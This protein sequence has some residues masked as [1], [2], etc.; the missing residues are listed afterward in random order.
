MPDIKLTTSDGLIETTI[1]QK[2][3]IYYLVTNDNLNSIKG[4]SILYDIFV[5]IAS[6]FWGAY[7]SILITLKSIS[8]D[9][10]WSSTVLPLLTLQDVFLCMSI[11]FTVLTLCMLYVSYSGLA[12]IKK[13]DV[14]NLS[15]TPDIQRNLEQAPE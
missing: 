3:E 6:I 9:D 1:K 8:V 2:Q 5:F 15:W 11:V 13:T 10:S 4:K 12:N 7:F 14:I